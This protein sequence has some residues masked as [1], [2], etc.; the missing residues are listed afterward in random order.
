M[1]ENFEA[2]EQKINCKFPRDFKNRLLE[3]SGKNIQLNLFDEPYTILSGITKNH[4]I[5]DEYENV[6]LCSNV[7]DEAYYLSDPDYIKIPFARN[8]TGDRF[9]FLYFLCKT[10]EESNGHIYLRDSDSPGSG[11]IKI[12]DSIEF[13]Y[14]E[15]EHKDDDVFIS[16]SNKKFSALIRYMPLPELIS[17]SKHYD[18]GIHTRENTEQKPNV[19]KTE[20]S[21]FIA[22]AKDYKQN[23]ARF[24]I[25]IE[26]V[27]NN[28]ISF[29]N[30]TY[31]LDIY[32]LKYNIENNVNYRIYYHKLICT[33]DCLKFTMESLEEKGLVS[34]QQFNDLIDKTPLLKMVE[35]Y[36]I[37]LDYYDENEE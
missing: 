34:K 10:G 33:L 18:G 7:L 3:F 29:S 24:Q 13:L 30:R 23:Y 6:V 21:A 17:I 19:I 2:I 22:I 15:V 28:T 32:G 27:H 14:G 4:E 11:R 1:I 31:D 16:Y 20:H 5:I 37:Q 12:A 8:T 26:L 25:D 9:K 36:F 35:K